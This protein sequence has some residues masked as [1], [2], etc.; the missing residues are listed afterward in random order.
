MTRNEPAI[1]SPQLML[2]FRH[3]ALLLCGLQV[4]FT[5]NIPPVF[6]NI[7]TQNLKVILGLIACVVLGRF[8]LSC[9][10]QEST[11]LG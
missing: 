2:A 11:A 8:S 6:H 5:D 1:L 7:Y 9:N 3:A 10:G 4:L